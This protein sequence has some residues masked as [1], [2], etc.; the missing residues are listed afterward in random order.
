MR[1]K[2]LLL[3]FSRPDHPVS[4][5]R[6][7]KEENEPWG[8]CGAHDCQVTSSQEPGEGST[9]GNSDRAADWKPWNFKCFLEV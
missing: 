1:R 7:C 8:T 6:L 2:Q 5:A 3:L 9:D 4:S